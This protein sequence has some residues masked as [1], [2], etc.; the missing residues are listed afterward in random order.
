MEK[1]KGGEEEAE[2]VGEIAIDK[3]EV[4]GDMEVTGDMVI[5]G[6]DDKN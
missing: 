6:C 1:W 3:M 2:A 4:V 5:S